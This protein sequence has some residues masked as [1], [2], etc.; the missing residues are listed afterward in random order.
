MPIGKYT[1]E[2]L[3]LFRKLKQK[4]KKINVDDARMIW[5]NFAGAEQTYN[6]AG[7]RNFCVR[8]DSDKLVDAAL[9]SGYNVKYRNEGDESL[10]Y[11]KVK[12]VFGDDR[13]PCQ[14][15]IKS[16]GKVTELTEETAHLVD[17]ADILKASV[18]IQPKPYVISLTNFG[19]SARLKALYLTVSEDKYAEEFFGSDDQEEDIPF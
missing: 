17:S 19:I 3:E 10:P 12:V 11:L 16:K 9:E 4:A 1:D 13:Y 15:F 18:V 2:E 7:D 8:L 14:I 5:L 6:N